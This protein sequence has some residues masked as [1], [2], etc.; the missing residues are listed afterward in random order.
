MVEF[1]T[2]ASGDLTVAS[3]GVFLHSRHN[4][5]KE[6]QR[7]VATFG[8]QVKDPAI[9]II[10]GS[11]LG[12]IDSLLRV[13]YPKA[14]LL[15][16]HSHIEIVERAD[17]AAHLSLNYQ[18]FCGHLLS[19][20]SF[21]VKHIS[22]E[23]LW[24]VHTVLWSAH[25]PQ[26]QALHQ[27]VEQFLQ[28]LKGSAFTTAQFGQRW[29]S[30]AFHN[31]LAPSQLGQLKPQ[32][33]VVLVASGETLM[34]AL[35]LLIA[36]RATF[37]LMALSSAL[38]C[39]SAHH[40]QPDLVV[41]IDGGFYAKTHLHQANSSLPLATVL[42][43]AG[44]KLNPVYLSFNT[45]IEQELLAGLPHI[46]VPWA[47][48]VAVSALAL[49]LKL[50]PNE[51]ILV[52]QDFAVETW[53]GH[54][55][56][57]SFDTAHEAQSHRFNPLPTIYAPLYWH[58]SATLPLYASWVQSQTWP[59]R[60]RRL[61]PSKVELAGIAAVSEEEFRAFKEVNVP[62][63]VW[64]THPLSRA[65]RQERLAA[66]VQKWQAPA[67]VFQLAL[68]LAP[69]ELQDFKETEH[70]NGFATLKQWAQLSETVQERLMAIHQKFLAF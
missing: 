41:S 57:H 53:H 13:R 6:A 59:A 32:Q 40:L 52:G 43:G 37:F 23:M 3:D 47:G 54:A 26:T 18:L 1:L 4:P 34:K 15:S 11:G 29:I 42:L 50:T 49:A 44:S 8:Q 19:L 21:L 7:Y 9:L 65:E 14:V 70:R 16:L 58:A 66:L 69:Q 10:I 22:E 55:R 38:T 64:Q 31:Y 30:N 24:G 36:Q 62:A 48:T 12:Y 28:R 67:Y 51:V 45:F 68:Y 60:L 5:I 25:L 20:E 39:L 33:R 46:G 56:P 17:L 27:R 2:S 61:F 63:V 35:P